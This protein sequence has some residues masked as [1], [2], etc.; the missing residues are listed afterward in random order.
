MSIERTTLAMVIQS[1]RWTRWAVARAWR[2]CLRERWRNTLRR[3]QTLRAV[4]TCTMGSG[5]LRELPVPRT[6]C[7]RGESPPGFPAPT[8]D[9]IVSGMGVVWMGA[10]WGES[11]GVLPGVGVRMD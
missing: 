7:A 10:G 1:W 3:R 2:K 5:F 4:A 6:G 9:V 8:L 11:T